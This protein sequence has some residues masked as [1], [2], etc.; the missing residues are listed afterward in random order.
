MRGGGV[1]TPV[2]CA[3]VC[4]AL[5]CLAQEATPAPAPAAPAGAIDLRAR[6]EA[7]LALVN[8]PQRFHA[9]TAEALLAQGYE[10]LFQID[11]T[12]LDLAGLDAEP[13][14][15][16]RLVFDLVLAIDERTATLHQEGGLSDGAAQAKR[17]VLRG[18]RFLREQ[19]LVRAHRRHPE[20]LYAG[21]RPGLAALPPT[22]EGLDHYHWTVAPARFGLRFQPDQLPRTFFILNEGDLPLSAAIARSA[23]EDNTFSHYSIGYVTDREQVLQGVRY[24]AGTLLTIEALIER[25]VVIEPFAYHWKESLLGWS[26]REAVFFLRDPA[27]QAAVDAAADAFFARARDA[28]E[29]GEPL[30]YDFQMG[31]SLTSAVEGAPPRLFTTNRFFCSGVAQL[32]GEAAGV[33]LFTHPSR[34][35]ASPNAR[36]LFRRWGL[37]P[38]RPLPSPG[39]GDVSTALVRV[40]EGVNLERIEAAH[41]RHAVM[42]RVFTWIDRDGYQV[43]SPRWFKGGTALITDLN[44]AVEGTPLDLGKVPNG[45]TPEVLQSLLP[46][47]FTTQAWMKR[48]EA[49]NQDSW[50]AQGRALTPAELAAHMERLRPEVD[51]DR[52]FVRGAEG[53]YAL[54]HSRPFP[55]SKPG[56]T[57]LTVERRGEALH[58]VREVWRGETRLA[59]AEG[60]AVQTG[61]KLRA[62][63]TTREGDHP[64]HLGWELERDGRIAGRL[65]LT[66]VERGRL[67]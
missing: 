45:I 38:D 16:N 7:A 40:A 63:F 8:D 5:P 17:R 4:L 34:L 25:G 30:G 19:V 66:R 53:R 9:G 57:L 6:L 10:Q 44:D 60:T 43:V 47:Q 56:R 13:E 26:A 1:L 31:H 61:K 32:I 14:A 29:R 20:R 12:Q 54:S 62:T 64:T 22:Q 39:D 67:E 28:L 24:P 27:R 48:L 33:D 52:W 11:P 50:R 2:V 46:M 3:L 41:L 37:D 59:R 21:G 58:V 51:V 35:E 42:E 15:L 49:L 55:W 36:A 65:S 23:S 18:L